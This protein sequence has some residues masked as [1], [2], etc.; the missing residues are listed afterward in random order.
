MDSSRT[1]KIRNILCRN[2]QP[3]H[4]LFPS[5]KALKIPKNL[6]DFPNFLRTH[7]A[8]PNKIFM[9]GGIK[10]AVCYNVYCISQPLVLYTRR[11]RM[12]TC[13]CNELFG[14]RQASSSP[15][16][17]FA[18]LRNGVQCAENANLRGFCFAGQRPG[19][20]TYNHFSCSH[21]MLVHNLEKCAFHL[22]CF[23]LISFL[24]ID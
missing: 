7:H 11:N 21:V 4:P 12:H 15:S 1:P 20:P 3:R 10:V 18:L 24:H 2:T 9:R 19:P 5:Q 23:S 13:T 6:K 22:L 8:A 14:K 16:S 17:S